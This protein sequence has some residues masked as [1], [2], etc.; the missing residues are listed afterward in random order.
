MGFPRYTTKYR[1]F[2]WNIPQGGLWPPPLRVFDSSSSCALC[3]ILDP[4]VCV[5]EGK[6]RVGPGLSREGILKS[7][8]PLHARQGCISQDYKSDYRKEKRERRELSCVGFEPMQLR[9]AKKSAEEK[10]KKNAID[11]SALSP[12]LSFTASRSLVVFLYRKL[13]PSTRDTLPTPSLLPLQ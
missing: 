1:R 13:I 12:S 11:A 6:K 2:L 10:K 9:C 7:Q 5:S 8:K 3:H 4:F